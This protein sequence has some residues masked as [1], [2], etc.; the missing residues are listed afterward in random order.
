MDMNAV[1]I[2]VNRPRHVRRPKWHHS[3]SNWLVIHR[4]EEG[5]RVN[6]LTAEGIHIY[7]FGQIQILAEFESSIRDE[8][9]D[10]F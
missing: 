9:W 4:E 8:V 6:P 1:L 10:M 2:L 3:W 7:A 5:D